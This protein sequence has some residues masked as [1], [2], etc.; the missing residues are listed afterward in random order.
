M[1]HTKPLTGI[2]PPLITPMTRPGILDEPAL[3]RVI[4]HV[5]HGGVSALFILGTTGEAPS[6]SQKIRIKM[7]DSTLQ[8]V[9]GRLPVLVGVTDTSMTDLLEL[10]NYVA[11]AGAQAIVAAPPYYYLA[12]QNEI[13]DWYRHISEQ[14]SLPLYLY[15]MPSMTKLTIAPETVRQLIDENVAIGIKDSS[16]DI[17]YLHNVQKILEDYPAAPVLVGDE[18]IMAEGFMAGTHGGV[19]GSANLLPHLFVAMYEAGRSGQNVRVRE[20]HQQMTQMHRMLYQ[21]P[22]IN[23]SIIAIIK[24]AMAHQGLCDNTMAMPIQSLS[25]DVMCILQDTIRELNLPSISPVYLPGMAPTIT[26]P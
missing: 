14:C 15:N 21:N 17:S 23:A 19:P 9:N 22:Q 10:A 3:A 11:Q 25:E 16:G 7:I 13:A 6:L 2:V 12:S 20:L 18:R 24:G 4:E 8:Q 1:Q 26:H 5:I